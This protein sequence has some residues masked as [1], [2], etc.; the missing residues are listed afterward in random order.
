MG[1]A[2]IGATGGITGSRTLS[3]PPRRRTSAHVAHGLGRT[4]RRRQE[5]PRPG[6]LAG[7]GIARSGPAVGFGPC[8]PSE[9]LD[10]HRR[11]VALAGAAVA[12]AAGIALRGLAWGAAAVVLLAGGAAGAPEAAV[13][14]LAGG[15]G[16]AGQRVG[17]PRLHLLA[18]G[19]L[20]HLDD[21]VGG[22]VDPVAAVARTSTRVAPAALAAGPATVARAP[23]ADAVAPVA[24][25]LADRAL[26]AVA[27]LAARTRLSEHG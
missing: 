12:L 22:G 6:D 8:W 19:V 17:V 4:G 27:A 2:S 21:D 14:A 24:A 16:V 10:R 15:A 7:Q 13:A 5:V 26:A 25:L 3:A 1:L 20:R 23:A 9:A 18:I 11:G